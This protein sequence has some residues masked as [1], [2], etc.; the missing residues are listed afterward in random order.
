MRFVFLADMQ[1][2]AYASFSGMT[3]A[4]VARLREERDEE[5][6]R[7]TLS[8][9]ESAS[10]GDNN[11]VGPILDC[12]RAYCTLFEIREAMEKVFGSYKEPVFF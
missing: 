8:A 5:K 10:S 6:V 9:L 3:E 12:A 7:S 1:L 2:G 11:L 4:D